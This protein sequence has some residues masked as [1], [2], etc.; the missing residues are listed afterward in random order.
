MNLSLPILTLFLASATLAAEPDIIEHVVANPRGVERVQ[1]PD[2][3]Y[4]ESKYGDH[5]LVE[6]EAFLLPSHPRRGR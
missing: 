3:T 4:K 6:A 5:K 2:G 1:Q